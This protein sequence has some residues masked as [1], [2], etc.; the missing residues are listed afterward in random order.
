MSIYV[1]VTSK[2]IA[3]V[4]R[5]WKDTSPPGMQAEI[6]SYAPVPVAFWYHSSFHL[7]SYNILIKPK[8]YINS[9]TYCAKF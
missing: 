1:D 7:L 2:T 5:T 6:I 9:T 4:H 8:V 3:Y